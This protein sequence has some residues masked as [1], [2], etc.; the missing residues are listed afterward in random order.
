MALHHCV[1]QLVWLRQLMQEIG[2]GSYVRSPTKVFADNKQANK[3]CAE[4]LVTAGN[5][6]FRTGYHYN[7]EAVRD[8]FVDVRYIN[9]AY[10]ISD[11]CTK[12]LA[13]NKISLFEAALHG[14]EVINVD[15]IA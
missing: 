2:L 1:K 4:D 14:H 10:N 5:M 6:Y 9:T 11:A 13:K 3:L 12:A 7:K 8:G 15:L